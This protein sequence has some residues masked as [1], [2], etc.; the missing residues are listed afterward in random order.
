MARR[1]S[2]PAATGQRSQLQK[3]ILQTKPV[4]FGDC[5]LHLLFILFSASVASRKPLLFSAFKGR[6]ASTSAFPRVAS[7]SD[8]PHVFIPSPLPPLNLVWGVE[9]P[10]LRMVAAVLWSL[11][12]VVSNHFFHGSA[13]P[14]GCLSVQTSWPSG[15]H[16]KYTVQMLKF[17]LPNKWKN[18]VGGDPSAQ[19][20]FFTK[21]PTR[22]STHS[23]GRE[24]RSLRLLALDPRTWVQSKRVARQ[25]VTCSLW[26][27]HT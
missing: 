13:Q 15:V 23:P 10:A 22:D 14:L 8:I 9:E 17:S 3:T 5:G 16:S 19:L 24:L 2:V 6:T 18:R 4:R 26:I 25:L 1:Q 20:K 12:I 27:G 7:M 11:L 21:R